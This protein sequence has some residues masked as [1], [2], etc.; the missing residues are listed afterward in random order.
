MINEDGDNGS[1]PQLL[2]KVE[3]PVERVHAGAV[4]G[5]H[6]TQ[7]LDG[8][9]HVRGAR[10]R[11]HTGNAVAHRLTRAGNVLARYWQTADRTDKRLPLP[12]LWRAI[13]SWSAR[14]GAMTQAA[15]LGFGKA[16]LRAAHRGDRRRPTHD[17]SK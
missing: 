9:L 17:P 13:A 2:A 3:R 8:E 4:D 10:M 15:V 1:L 6:P 7:R 16:L 5:V 14:H 12:L 11:K